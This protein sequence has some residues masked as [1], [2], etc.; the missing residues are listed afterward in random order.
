MGRAAKYEGIATSVPAAK[1]SGVITVAGFVLMPASVWLLVMGRGGYSKV[2]QH[3]MVFILAGVTL[4][5]LWL[6]DRCGQRGHG[7]GR[8]MTIV[9]AAKD[10]RINCSCSCWGDAGVGMAGREIGCAV[11]GRWT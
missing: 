10:L 9:H 8:I 1:G 5:S 7:H 4:A 3:L 2:G 6:S 11:A